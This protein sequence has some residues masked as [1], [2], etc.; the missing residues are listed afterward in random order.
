MKRQAF[1]GAVVLVAALVWAVLATSSA[2][3]DRSAYVMRDLGS[4]GG[5]V[6]LANAINDKGQVVI[7]RG[8]EASDTAPRTSTRS[9]VWENG[10]VRWLGTLAGGATTASA[11]NGRGQVVGESVVGGIPHAFLWQDGKMRDIGVLGGNPGF[12]TLA[13][14]GRGEVV[15]ARISKG[16]APRA[17]VWRNGRM[18]DLGTLGGPMSVA[19]GISERGQVVGVS[20]TVSG[21]THPFLWQ[22]G[23]MRDIAT[24]TDGVRLIWASA[25]SDKGQ[26]AGAGGRIVGKDSVDEKTIRAHLWSNG[27]ITDLGTLPGFPFSTAGAINNRGQIVG[28]AQAKKDKPRAFLWENGRMTDLGGNA[29]V[30]TFAKAINERGQ[31]VGGALIGGHLHAVLWTPTGG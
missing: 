28:I 29:T 13:L 10:R 31:I 15:G 27:K 4:F 22:N 12:G 30:T 21:V 11:I 25:I 8:T 19:Y 6:A 24:P 7:A 1:G 2:T 16:G 20:D 14:N 9:L 26:V 23:K 3:A 18:L 5:T 17:F